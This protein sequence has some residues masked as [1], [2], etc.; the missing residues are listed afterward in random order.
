MSW[1]RL[2]ERPSEALSPGRWDTESGRARGPRA[3]PGSV[4]A[5]GPRSS[6]RRD[7]GPSPAV[8]RPGSLRRRWRVPPSRSRGRRPCRER[9]RLSGR[10]S[11]GSLTGMFHRDRGTQ[12]PWVALRCRPRA[13]DIG[14]LSV[15]PVLGLL[16]GLLLGHPSCKNRAW[17]M[18]SGQ[19]RV[20]W[21]SP[22]SWLRTA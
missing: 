15:C 22:V 4:S 2:T 19:S 8:T 14:G 3:A 20:L 13:P 10:R 16:S 11:A 18:L 1:R 21:R 6:T 5:N 7:A 17:G 9:A 12:T